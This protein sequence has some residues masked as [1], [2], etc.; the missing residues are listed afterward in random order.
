MVTLSAKDIVRQAV[1]IS[2]TSNSN[3]T[4]YY[5]AT[6]ILSSLYRDLYNDL[7]NSGNSYIETVVT[8]DTELS[9][10]GFYK[11]AYVGYKGGNEIT[12]SSL[13]TRQTGGYYIENDTLHMPAGL[14]EVKLCPMPATI[15]VPDDWK[16]VTLEDVPENFTNPALTVD[17][18]IDG[19]E[20]LYFFGELIDMSDL[21]DWLSKDDT[22]I[23]N[24]NVSDP[25][26][27]VSYSDETIRLYDGEGSYVDVNP[28]VSKGKVFRG[29]VVAFTAD[30]DTG[31][32]VIIQDYNNGKYYYGSFVPD[33]VLSY[34][35]NTFFNVLIYRLAAILAS[36]QNIPNPY[37]QNNL[38]PDAERRFFET[39]SKGGPVRFA[40][41]R[42]GRGYVR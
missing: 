9:L 25:F 6:N 39:L 41:V 37:L 34:P 28:W 12:R 4:D 33:T 10:N 18:E 36:L 27:Y 23:V 31:K 2:Q 17:G 11:V 22:T 42:G 3:I 21:P 15:T 40:N 7:I 30:T 19:T 5:V 24:V 13:R 8:G 38:L 16:E 35:D 26:I 1:Y 29:K 32:G 14:K 20:P